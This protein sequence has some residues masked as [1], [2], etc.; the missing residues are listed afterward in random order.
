MTKYYKG[1]LYMWFVFALLSA[2]FAAL[3]SILAKIGI[4]DHI[5]RTGTLR[6]KV[7]GTDHTATLVQIGLQLPASPGVVAQ[8]DD[9]RTG[10]A[11]ITGKLCVIG[12]KLDEKGIA[13]LFGV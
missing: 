9:I 12:S 3:T 2:I 11:A 10:G 8:S 1:G 6:C 4:D 5:P 7:C 13:V